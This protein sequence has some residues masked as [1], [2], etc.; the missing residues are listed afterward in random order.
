MSLGRG[1]TAANRCMNSSG[2][3]SATDPLPVAAFT[4]TCSFLSCVFE[5]SD[6]TDNASIS[7]YSWNFGDGGVATGQNPPH[8]F[9][10]A[11]TFSVVLTVTDNANQID[12]KT[13]SIKVTALDGLTGG[14]C[15]NCAKLHRQSGRHGRSPVPAQWRAL[16][17][18]D[19]EYPPWLAAWPSQ[20]EFRFVPVALG[21]QVVASAAGS[22]SNADIA[23][24]GPAGYYVWRIASKQD[25]GA[26][27][28]YMQR[29]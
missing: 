23:F 14:P 20:C 3:S 7:V 26:Y 21:W 22:S 9:S 6:S 29:P 27:S 1:T 15:T 8:T 10:S 2:D 11:G 12:T 16:F 4:F 13:K 17:Y 28:F 5:G 19:R 24:T 18:F 25:S